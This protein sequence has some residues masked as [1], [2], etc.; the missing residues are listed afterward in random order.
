[1]LVITAGSGI[2]TG[3]NVKSVLSHGLPRGLP[4]PLGVGTSLEP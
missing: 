4:S 2:T 1:M 3:E